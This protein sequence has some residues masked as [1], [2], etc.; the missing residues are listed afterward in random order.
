MKKCGVIM[1]IK[2]VKDLKG[3][4]VEDT[5]DWLYSAKSLERHIEKEKV[6]LKAELIQ[7]NRIRIA[8]IQVQAELH[9]TVIEYYEHMK[10]LVEKSISQG[11]ELIAF[12]ENIHLPL[13]GI[14]PQAENLL[15]GYDSFIKSSPNNQVKEIFFLLGPYIEKLYKLT[16]SNLAKKYQVYIMAGSITAP[17][18]NK[19]YNTAYF[20]GPEGE[21]LGSQRKLHL[22]TL[23]EAI[24]LA[25]GDELNVIT[26]PFGKVAFPICMDAT[27]F[28]TFHFA[29]QKGADIVL[30]S[31]ANN[32]EYEY[33]RAFRGTWHRVQ[34][35][36]VFGVKSTLVGEL[37]GIVFTGRAAI[38]APVDLTI[39]K[40]GIIQEASTYGKEEI[41]VGDLDLN[42]L[43]RYR[44]NDPIL[45]DFNQ[46][47][48]EQYVSLMKA[49]CREG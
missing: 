45:S 4:A 31:I 10:R 14:A 41:V 39:N 18:E 7:S 16:F 20:F 42:A 49:Y 28:E 15:T 13:M 44:E 38:F 24:G 11:A 43:R 29:R 37:G 22:T 36:R 47:V 33:Y 40:D 35:S 3:V 26:M 21:C 5:I 25:V 23:E 1:M 32:E 34:E 46:E 9:S 48:Y 8:A 2:I 19:L 30:V 12:P 17:F 6:D 27:Y